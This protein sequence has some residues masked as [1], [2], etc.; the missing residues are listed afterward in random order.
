VQAAN[1]EWLFI[2]AVCRKRRKNHA[3]I[4]KLKTLCCERQKVPSEK[5]ACR[6]TIHFESFLDF[7]S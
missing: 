5:M 1:E 3:S 7:Y 4:A 2:F 6:K